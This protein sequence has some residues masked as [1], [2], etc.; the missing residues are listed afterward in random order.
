MF[1]TD[2]LRHTNAYSINYEEDSESKL[3]SLHL[4]KK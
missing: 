1:R 3:G 2:N 4:A